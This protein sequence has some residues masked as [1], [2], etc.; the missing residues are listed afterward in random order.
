MDGS[1]QSLDEGRLA[2][3][4]LRKPADFLQTR[5]RKVQDCCSRQSGWSQS[6]RQGQRD[7][8]DMDFQ[9]TAAFRGTEGCIQPGGH[10]YS[11]PAQELRRSCFSFKDR[12]RPH[13]AVF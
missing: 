13:A 12:A 5:E 9:K 1:Y 3:V 8:Y 2:G 4:G 6:S 11:L 10:F 7:Q